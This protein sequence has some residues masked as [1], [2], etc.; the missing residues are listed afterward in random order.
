MTVNDLDD[1][2]ILIERVLPDPM[3]FVD[4]VLQQLVGRMSDAA[5]T[6]P[7]STTVVSSYDADAHER[8]REHNLVVAAALGACECWGLEDECPQC[9]GDGRSG[10]LPPD[11]QLFDEYVRPAFDRTR[12]ARATHTVNTSIHTPQ[13]GETP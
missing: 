13:Q 9:F 4:R 7:T 12:A 1:L 2:E 8:L 3:G 6:T 5:P 10:W 11:H